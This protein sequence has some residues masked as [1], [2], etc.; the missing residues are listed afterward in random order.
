MYSICITPSEETIDSTHC[1]VAIVSGTPEAV[2]VVSPV[3]LRL[4]VNL[5]VALLQD[6]FSYSVDGLRPGSVYKVQ[7]QVLSA[8][9]SG[10]SVARTLHSPQLPSTDGQL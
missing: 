8:G 2:V 1:H 5:P 4:G 10:P 9:G 6:Q 7:V 3:L